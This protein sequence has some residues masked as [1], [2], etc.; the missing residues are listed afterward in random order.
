MLSA[1]LVN[2]TGGHFLAG[3]SIESTHH[4]TVPALAFS[5]KYK[6]SGYDR[7]SPFWAGIFPLAVKQDKL[8]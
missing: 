6:Q 1:S 7:V 4:K 8:L 3:L 5:V 2:L